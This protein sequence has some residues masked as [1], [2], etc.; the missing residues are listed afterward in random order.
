MLAAEVREKLSGGPGTPGFYIFVALADSLDCF[1]EVLPLPFQIGSQGIV[2]SGGRVLATPFGVLFQLRLTLR[3]ES[4]HIHGW[5]QFPST[6]RKTFRG[7]V[8]ANLG[9]AW[10]Y[11]FFARAGAGRFVR[12]SG[13]VDKENS[14]VL[15]PQE[16]KI[17]AN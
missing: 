10:S 9:V 7:P 14:L 12:P 1:R 3:L 6:H 15:V 8:K 5:P 17:S 16:L 13:T 4:D 2:K 11:S